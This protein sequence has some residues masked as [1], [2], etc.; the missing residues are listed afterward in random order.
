MNISEAD[1]E[2]LKAIETLDESDKNIIVGYI[3][4][5]KKQFKDEQLAEAN[6]EIERLQK[7]SLTAEDVICTNCLKVRKFSKKCS[8]CGSGILEFI[9]VEAIKEGT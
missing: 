6:K 2:F 7:N 8:F 5:L 9:G 4:N 1:E 3:E